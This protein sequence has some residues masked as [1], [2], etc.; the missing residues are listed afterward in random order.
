[1]LV[2]AEIGVVIDDI[3]HVQKISEGN[4]LV[5]SKLWLATAVA[6]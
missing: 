3:E 1:M 4:G 2:F 5:T 6:C